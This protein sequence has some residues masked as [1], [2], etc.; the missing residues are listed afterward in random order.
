MSN[1]SN[2]FAV[3]Y[4]PETLPSKHDRNFCQIQRMSVIHSL[5]TVLKFLK[6][7]FMVERLSEICVIFFSADKHEAN[8][9]PTLDSLR[10]QHFL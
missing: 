7:S 4:F 6:R 1:L 5:E 10:A 8:G 3:R 9:I 2:V